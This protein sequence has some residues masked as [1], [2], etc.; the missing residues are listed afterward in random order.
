MSHPRRFS[1]SLGAG[2][3]GETLD[4]REGGYQGAVQGQSRSDPDSVQ[5]VQTWV[6]RPRVLPVA[7]AGERRSRSAMPTAAVTR[8][9]G[10]RR[11][12]ARSDRIW[13][14]FG[15]GYIG[16]LLL[17]ASTGHGWSG[18]LRADAA[19]TREHQRHRSTRCIDTAARL[20]TPS[21]RGTDRTSRSVHAGVLSGI[22]D[23]AAPRAGR[24]DR[25]R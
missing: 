2:D 9:G 18:S 4:L 24:I 20:G 13:T 17:K 23:R 6:A 25:N 11:F 5:Q 10:L 12:H 14:G 16:D 7:R 1:C 8:D 22:E 3:A 21:T 19:K 15:P